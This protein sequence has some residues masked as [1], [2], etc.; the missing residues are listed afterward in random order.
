MSIF[1][2]CSRVL[3]L[4]QSIRSLVDKYPSLTNKRSSFTGQERSVVG[5][6]GLLFGR[7]RTFRE[8]RRS[9][10]SKLGSRIDS[11]TT[12]AAKVCSASSN[13]AHW[14][15]SVAHGSTDEPHSLTSEFVLPDVTHHGAIHEA[16]GIEISL[17]GAVHEG[18]WAPYVA[19]ESVNEPDRDRNVARD[20]GREP[21]SVPQVVHEWVHEPHQAPNGAHESNNEAHWD[22]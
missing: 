22:R 5:V 13:R 4:P 9:F 11:R 14:E 6:F 15:R 2:K 18:L 10:E 1:N 21:H 3:S 16:H 17:M 12:R 7:S 8:C 19:H 20:L